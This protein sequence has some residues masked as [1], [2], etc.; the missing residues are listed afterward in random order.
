VRWKTL[1]RENDGQVTDE[2]AKA[3]LGD[4]YDE[5]LKKNV[6]SGGV[7]CGKGPLSGAINSKVITAALAG[8]MTFWARMG[9]SDGSERKFGANRPAMLRDIP[10]QPWVLFR[11][12]K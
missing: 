4:T 7:L 6:T 1:L 9:V 11:L 10:S 12:E 2:K 8:K 5:V 3:F